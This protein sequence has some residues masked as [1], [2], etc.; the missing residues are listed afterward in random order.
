MDKCNAVELN[1]A[2]EEISMVML[3]MGK[4]PNGSGRINDK[5]LLIY[6]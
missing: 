1:V 2:M 3:L 5:Q 4:P 6:L